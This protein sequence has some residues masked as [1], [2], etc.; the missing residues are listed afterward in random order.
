MVDRFFRGAISTAINRIFLPDITADYARIVMWDLNKCLDECMNNFP[1]D[2]RAVWIDKKVYRHRGGGIVYFKFYTS[3]NHMHY[4][5]QFI[6]LIYDVPALRIGR[7]IRIIDIEYLD[8]PYWE[9]LV[10]HLEGHGI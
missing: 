3:V 8:G 4:T 1:I 9:S 2:I 5:P 10:T 6:K 7:Q